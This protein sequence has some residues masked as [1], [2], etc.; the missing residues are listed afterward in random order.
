M[1]CRCNTIDG[2]QKKAYTFFMSKKAIFMAKRLD[3]IAPV[4]DRAYIAAGGGLAAVAGALAATAIVVCVCA[5]ENARTACVLLLCAGFCAQALSLF[6]L[7]KE[8]VRNRFMSAVR[9][10]V[11]GI[12]TLAALVTAAVLCA[13]Y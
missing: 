8:T 3:R 10:L 6:F 4:S 2:A 13:I 5:A 12:L 9:F 11:L 1:Q 7:I